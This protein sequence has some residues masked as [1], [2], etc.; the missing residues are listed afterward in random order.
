VV[1]LLKN[2]E[3]RG[4]DGMAKMAYTV[5]EAIVT[6]LIVSILYLIFVKRNRGKRYDRRSQG[7]A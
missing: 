4:K 7:E 6:L 2:G 1:V 3:P 5:L